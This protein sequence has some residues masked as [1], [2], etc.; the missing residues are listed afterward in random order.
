MIIYKTTNLIS[1]KFYIGKD[2]YNNENYIGS[3]KI[4]KNAIYKYGKENFTKEIIEF[5]NNYEEL[6]EKEIFWID[7]TSATENGYNIATG[8][9]GGDTISNHPNRDEICKNHSEWMLKNNPTRGRKRTKDEIDRWKYS[10]I[11]K[12]RGENNPMFGSKRDQSTKNKISEAR[13]IWWIELSE[14][15]RVIIGKK[16]SESNKGKT[17][18]NWTGEQKIAHSEWMTLNNPMKD[19]THT[20][21]VKMLLSELNKKPKSDKTKDMI[22]ESLIEYYKKGNKPKNTKKILIDDIIY[23]GYN[24]ASVSLNIPI[25][26]IRN[27]IK[28][29]SYK[30]YNHIINDF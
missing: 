24:D 19:K 8:G 25:S 23:E 9:D 12:Y 29:K 28:S 3:G 20:P 15:D 27:R 11:G 22:R 4:L 18:R 14:E 30:N 7:F 17:G 5:C 1:G 10:Y 2:K 16:I 21:E 13:K 26:T 6:N